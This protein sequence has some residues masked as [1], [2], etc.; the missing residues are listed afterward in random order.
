MDT[1]LLLDSSVL[2]TAL[3]IYRSQAESLKVVIPVLFLIRLLFLYVKFSSVNEYFDAVRDLLFCTILLYNFES[4]LNILVLIPS[5]ANDLH[6][7]SQK[8]V[9]VSQISLFGTT[10][11]QIVEWILA[12]SYWI[13]VTIYITFMFLLLI[14]GPYIFMF[15]TLIPSYGMI[16]FYFSVLVIIS[17]WPLAWFAINT[18]TKGIL[19]SVEFLKDGIS[20]GIVLLL[21]GVVKALAP[22]VLLLAKNVVGQKLAAF[23]GTLKSGFKPVGKVAGTGANA[24]KAGIGIAKGAVN[25]MRGKSGSYDGLGMPIQNPSNQSFAN[26]KLGK[27]L[28][29]GGAAYSKAS[30]SAKA[31][32]SNMRSKASEFA[33]SRYSNK[34]DANTNSKT[35]QVPPNA[36]AN[37]RTS[38]GRVNSY[39]DAG[40]SHTNTK[41]TSQSGLNSVSDRAQ[42]NSK[43][44]MQSL[45]R[46]KANS[47]DASMSKSNNLK[48]S[49]SNSQLNKSNPSKATGYRHSR[50]QPSQ[51]NVGS[52]TKN[53]GNIKSNSNVRPK[54]NN[55]NK[56]FIK[57]N[58]ETKEA[59]NYV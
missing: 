9:Y 40:R 25:N 55:P 4:I 44:V 59:F 38:T 14:L 47:S 23:A 12:A 24:T 51:K 19:D 36:S 58:K 3:K 16:K 39:S 45:S 30:G 53:P 1:N 13:A 49:T 46:F 28:K 43:S 22:I 6:P 54:D 27:G 48:N 33:K 35:D 37:S 10:M 29:F 56:S 2:Q 11:N 41:N 5:Y 15:G 7:I 52:A 42:K 20:N 18:V 34:Y 17:M 21:S 8:E 31:G 50:S 57:P 32:F 26:S